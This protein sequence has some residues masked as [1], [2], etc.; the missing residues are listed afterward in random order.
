MP[1]R[2]AFETCTCEVI[3]VWTPEAQKLVVVCGKESFKGAEVRAARL[4]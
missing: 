1:G 3:D 4:Q 2:K